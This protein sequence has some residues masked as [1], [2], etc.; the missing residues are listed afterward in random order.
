[1]DLEVPVLIIAVESAANRGMWSVHKIGRFMVALTFLGAGLNAWI[2]AIHTSATIQKLDTGGRGVVICH[3]DREGSGDANSTNDKSAPGKSCFICT[4][5][6][7]FQSG[8]AGQPLQTLILKK[9]GEI[10]IVL[11]E[12]EPVTE[13]RLR[14]HFNRGPPRVS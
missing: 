10:K 4:A 14:R 5:L 12:A 11:A 13:R 7:A 6:A 8:I 2:L 3:R 9:Q 1:L